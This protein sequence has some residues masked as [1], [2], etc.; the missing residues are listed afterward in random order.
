MARFNT[1]YPNLHAHIVVSI[2]PADAGD[3][4]LLGEPG[5]GGR[6]LAG[7]SALETGRA[8][9]RFH[10]GQSPGGTAEETARVPGMPGVRHALGER[11]DA[12]SDHRADDQL[13]VRTVSARPRTTDRNE[14]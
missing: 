4:D 3:T 7:R 13:F 11:R 8:R 14:K 10:A 1:V 5:R 9:R 6:E 12:R 2:L